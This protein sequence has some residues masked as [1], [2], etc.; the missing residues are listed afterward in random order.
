[1]FHHKY[2]KY[3]IKCEQ[4]SQ[5]MS[6]GNDIFADQIKSFTRYIYNLENADQV[7]IIINNLKSKE[8][9]YNLRNNVLVHINE[10]C[11][12]S[13]IQNVITAQ[14]TDD[15]QIKNNCE[16]FGLII[17][18]NLST[19]AMIDEIKNRFNDMINKNSDDIINE[20]TQSPNEMLEVKHLLTEKLNDE[21][22]LTKDISS[23]TPQIIKDNTNEIKQ[24][25]DLLKTNDLFNYYIYFLIMIMGHNNNI[26]NERIKNI[27]MLLTNKICELMMNETLMIGGTN[28]YLQN[29]VY[30]KTIRTPNG[31]RTIIVHQQ[32]KIIL[33]NA[34][35]LCAGY[36][37]K[38][39]KFTGKHVDK[40]YKDHK[41]E[42][43]AFG[44]KV[45]EISKK[46]GDGVKTAYNTA[47]KYV[48]ETYEKIKN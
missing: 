13:K 26:S 9:F 45:V 20:M 12:K 28:L 48:T 8:D 22:E 17:K 47:S 25:M 30:T 36:I 7:N 16:Q 10:L 5:I 3:K 24:K 42:F 11:D 40:F 39:M 2:M 34:L 4:L 46:I 23:E 43:D 18:G 21:P 33:S 14:T 38:G 29:T 32:Q 44:N 41:D 35:I 27:L 6:G 19:G 1:M 31:I 37:W 15:T